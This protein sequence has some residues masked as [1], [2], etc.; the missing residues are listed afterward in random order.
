MAHL[1]A[2]GSYDPDGDDIDYQWKLAAV[3]ANGGASLSDVRGVTTELA[4]DV[5][6]VW[7]VK[8]VTSD[9]RLVSEPDVVLVRARKPCETDM[10]CNDD[11]TCTVDL[12]EKK[13]CVNS[14]V[15][16]G[17]E[18]G[19]RYCSGLGWMRQT[20]VAGECTGS[21]IV[22]NCD[23]GNTCTVDSCEAEAGCTRTVV[24]TGTD[25][26]VCLACNSTGS[27]VDDP[28][29]NGDCP[30]CEQC[31]SGGTC[32]DQLTGSDVKNECTQD[33][34]NTGTCD[35]SG[36]C[37]FENLGTDCGVC[38]ACNSTGSCVDDPAQNGDCPLCKQ[39]APGGTCVDQ[40]TGS[41]VKNEC[42]QDDCNTGDC[43]GAGACGF[44]DDKTLCSGDSGIC[45]LGTCHVGWMCCVD[46]DCNDTQ[47]CTTDRCAIGMCSYAGVNAGTPCDG[48]DGNYCNSTCDG[49]DGCSGLP[50]IC[51]DGN[52]CNGAE[53]CDTTNGSCRDG[54]DLPA[55][56]YCDGNDLATCD[57]EGNQ[58]SSEACVLGCNTAP[59]PDRCYQVNPSN[60]DPTLLCASSY[61]LVITG[62]ASIDTEN[63]TISGVAGG[64]IVF[65]T[66]VQG[67]PDPDIGVFSFNSIDIQGDVTVTGGNA[68]AL[69]ACNDIT[70]AGAIDASASGRAGGPGGY[71]GGPVGLN[72]DGPCNG[73]AAGDGSTLCSH[74][75]AAGSG[76]GGHGGS[77]GSGGEVDCPIIQ[78]DPGAGG[79]VCGVDTLAPLAGGSGGAGGPNVPGAAPPSSPGDG[80]G[81]G[82]AVEI[83]AG[84]SLLMTSTGGITVAGDGGGPATNAG[85]AGG[86]SGGA[87]LI[88]AVS[89]D[90]ESGAFL[91]ANGGGGGGGDCG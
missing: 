79:G 40:L 86:G 19:S 1:N 29:Q 17:T 32:I 36:A 3:P 47:E 50:V 68:L 84:A 55:S 27:C 62:P 24:A 75:C 51:D 57:E 70:I 33:D 59:D 90:M 61:D 89:I 58:T 85:G 18:C 80:G 69:L 88:E 15:E 46:E 35:G 34:C 87:I 38:L 48:G 60:I 37:G 81:G 4:P 16:N 66:K 83:V 8:L 20:C 2:S 56:D 7:V 72:G 25:C 11:N 44:E 52:I 71:D 5:A 28:T 54:T 45:C 41:D 76:G 21:E 43:D 14:P 63:G 64:D 65:N 39:C 13:R 49:M 67:G 42:A 9:G 12:C 77:G 30:L 6:G 91:A 10:E 53:T 73:E 26:G 31:A 82:G 22:D 74:Y 23:D 78:L